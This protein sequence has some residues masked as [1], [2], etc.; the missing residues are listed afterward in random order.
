MWHAGYEIVVLLDISI[1]RSRAHLR[2][3]LPDYAERQSLSDKAIHFMP[4]VFKASDQCY[5]KDKLI[6]SFLSLLV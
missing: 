3:L 1:E 4:L 5:L 2:S 6:F